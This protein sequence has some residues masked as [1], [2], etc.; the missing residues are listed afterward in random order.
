MS[1]K[2]KTR[3]D[4]K[5]PKGQTIVIK[6]KGRNGPR[7]ITMERQKEAGFGKWKIIKNEKV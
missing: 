5:F 4:Q 2:K 7:C 6:V 3:K 1:S